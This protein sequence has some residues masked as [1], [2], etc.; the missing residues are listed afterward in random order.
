MRSVYTAA[1]QRM[2]RALRAARETKGLTQVQVAKRL[3]RP[4]SFV[5]NCESGERRVDL[6]EAWE[7]AQLYECSV[8]DF[9][10]RA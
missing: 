6:I 2:L 1:Y 9:L 4:Q 5:S 8:L 10:P 7:F 3:K